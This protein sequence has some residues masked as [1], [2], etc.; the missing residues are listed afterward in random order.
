MPLITV[1]PGRAAMRK[2]HWPGAIVLGK[3]HHGGEGFEV[4]VGSGILQCDHGQEAKR[5]DYRN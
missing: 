1:K 2:G 5:D 4:G 3:A